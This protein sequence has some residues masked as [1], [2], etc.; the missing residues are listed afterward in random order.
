MPFAVPTTRSAAPRAKD[1]SDG[2]SDP[3]VASD[4]SWRVWKGHEICS[5][6]KYPL[7]GVNASRGSV[8]DPSDSEGPGHAVRW[9]I[10]GYA[11]TATAIHPYLELR[12]DP[13]GTVQCDTAI[14]EGVTASTASFDDQAALVFLEVMRKVML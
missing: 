4:A 6:R 2:L 3:L 7:E 14:D 8:D 12:G 9:S 5:E 13:R 11:T 10:A 1:D